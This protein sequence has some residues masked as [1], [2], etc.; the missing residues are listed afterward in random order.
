AI[1]P[2][3]VGTDYYSGDMH[4]VYGGGYYPHVR[5][6]GEVL[7]FKDGA[8]DFIVSHHSLEHMRDTEKTLREWLRVLKEGGRIAIVMPDKRFGPFGDPS[9]VSECTPQEFYEIIKRISNIKTIEYNTLN[10]RFSFQA[11]IEKHR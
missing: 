11:I 4:P 6:M 8:F 10:N 1:S 3:C 9:H 7:P 5:S 2:F